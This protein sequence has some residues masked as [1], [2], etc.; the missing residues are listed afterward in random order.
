M[1]WLPGGSSQDS[2]TIS[3]GNPRES[4]ACGSEMPLLSCFY[5]PWFAVPKR[6]PQARETVR[7]CRSGRLKRAVCAEHFS[8]WRKGTENGSVPSEPTVGAVPAP[9]TAWTLKWG[10]ERKV[11]MARLV[12]TYGHLGKDGPCA[13]ILSSTTNLIRNEKRGN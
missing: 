13:S 1:V 10:Q 3:P 4:S 12:P 8:V 9:C 6:K 2:I 5:L 11:A 7:G